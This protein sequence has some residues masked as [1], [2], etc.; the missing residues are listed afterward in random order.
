MRP[1]ISLQPFGGPFWD[2][3][4]GKA[5]RIHVL[6]IGRPNQIGSGLAEFLHVSVEVPR[7]TAEIFV[8]RELL[9]VDEN[10]YDSPIRALIATPHKIQV[11]AMKRSH[12]RHE[13]HALTASPPGSH[14][15]A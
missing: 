1:E 9:G 2:N 5:I 12:C 7:V 3:A 8:R 6:G 13:R 4:R 10:R 11:T 14:L 15:R